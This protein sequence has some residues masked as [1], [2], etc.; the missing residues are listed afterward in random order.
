MT[1]SDCLMIL[2]YIKYSRF[3]WTYY[4]K[5]WHMNKVEKI[6]TFKIKRGQYLEFLMAET[7]KL[8]RSTEN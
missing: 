2:F 8:F 6:I 7:I 5:T 1:N 4:Q 3:V